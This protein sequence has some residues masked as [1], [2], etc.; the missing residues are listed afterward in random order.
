MAHSLTVTFGSGI[1]PHIGDYHPETLEVFQ[2][3]TYPQAKQQEGE[4]RRLSNIPPVAV[5]NPEDWSAH[6]GLRVTQID[7]ATSALPLP[8]SS[9]ENRRAIAIQNLGPSTLYISDSESVT[10]GNGYPLAPNSNKEIAIDIK[11]NVRV[12]GISDGT[13]DVRVLE[14]S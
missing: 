10:T 5:L 12:Y 8:G 4:L 13:C 9:L 3:G 2:G 7:V 11:G 1:L 14:V 6:F